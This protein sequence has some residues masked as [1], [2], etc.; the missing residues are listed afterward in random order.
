M[1]L[2]NVLVNE[3]GITMDLK[4]VGWDDFD[5]NYPMK[6]L[7]QEELV[8]VL[9]LLKEEIIKNG[10]LFSGEDHQNSLSGMPVFSDGTC[11]RASMRAWGSLMADIHEGPG[12]MNLTYMDFYM[13]T[14]GERKMPPFESVDIEP[15]KVDMELPGLIIKE[16]ME[17]IEQT[18]SFGM[19]FMTTDKVLNQIYK[20]LK[21]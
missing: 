20:N 19:E 21:K 8:Y 14:F 17:L 6:Q 9:K 7:T 1:L 2:V 4:I 3:G 15:A 13:D 18:L 5:S 10:Y 12:G 11:L 16:D